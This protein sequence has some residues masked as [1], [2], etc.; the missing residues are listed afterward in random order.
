MRSFALL[1]S[2][3]LPLLGVQAGKLEENGYTVTYD[4]DPESSVNIMSPSYTEYTLNSISIYKQE[5]RAVIYIAENSYE[6]HHDG[7]LSLAEIFEEVCSLRDTVPGN[8]DLLVFDDL[9]SATQT[10]ISTYRRQKKIDREE[11]IEFTPGTRGWSEFANL[12]YYSKAK[13]VN[14]GKS[15]SKI[16]IKVMEAERLWDWADRDG[17]YDALY[18]TYSS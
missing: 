5:S 7:Q 15:I 1:A 10:K 13:A 16:Q 18:F 11:D 4:E 12:H 9:D 8:L 2:L 17:S 14:P 6:P 3:L